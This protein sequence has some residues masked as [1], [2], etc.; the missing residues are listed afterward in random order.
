MD[1]KSE[2]E[3]LF[4]EIEYFDGSTGILV[5]WVNVPAL[6][7]IAD[8]DFYMYYGN[9]ECSNQEFPELVWDS[10]YKV[11]YHMNY[12]SGN[13][14]DSTSYNNDCNTV[15]GSPDYYHIGKIGY[16][17]N[18]EKST[19]EA[20]EDG[21]ILDG[22]DELTVEAWINLEEYHSS[23]C[24][25][26]SHEDAWYFHVN[27]E[28]HT[29]VFDIHGGV[30]GSAAHDDIICPLGTWYYAVGTWSDPSDRMQLFTNGELKDTY[31]E[32]LSMQNS[33]D[34]FAIGY[35][36][37]NGKYFDGAI[38]EIRV[39]DIERSEEWIKTTFNNQNNPLSFLTIG[40]EETK[41][42]SNNNVL[43][44]QLFNRYPIFY[45]LLSLTN[46]V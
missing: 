36:D 37:N 44:F 34:H 19:E 32:S 39:S 20:F 35:Q 16:A 24:I 15:F 8:I 17:I 27:Y 14:I 30:S 18:F 9:L 3:Q 46:F 21:D 2:A 11:V 29:V 26:A 45:K 5:A 40:P 43:F 31:I 23:H 7:T 4:H 25:I 12:I 28:Y 41:H 33:P 1:G 22:L 13:L 10:N 38:D 6:S 42:K